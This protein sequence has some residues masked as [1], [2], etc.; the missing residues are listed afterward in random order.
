MSEKF[1][2]TTAIDY[3]NNPPH[4]GTAYE[5][6]CADVIARLHRLLGIDTFF[7]MGNDEHSIN[8]YKK[9]KSLSKTPEEYCDEM[10][11]IFK[12]TWRKLNI[13]YDHFIRT[14]S[15]T[16]QKAVI[17][18]FQR[19]K[20]KG[21]IYKGIY[22]G[23]YCNSCEAYIK[24]Q[25]LLDGR[26]CPLHEIPVERLEEENYFFKLSEFQ[27]RLKS[28]ITEHPEF[29]QPSARRNEIL[30]V[31]DKG[32][33]DISISRKGLDFGIKVADAEDQTIY[34][35]FDAL[36]NYITG[37]GFVD[38]NERFNRYWPADLHIIGKDIT[39]FH[40]LIWPAMLMAIELPL[41]RKIF[42]HGFIYSKGL[43]LSKTKGILIN[44]IDLVEKYGADPLR[45][46]LVRE[47]NFGQDGNFSMENFIN[48]Y[49][50]DLANDYGNLVS[51]ISVMAKKYLDNKIE[52]F[53]DMIA[54]I[55]M[56]IINC[57]YSL[58]SFV[59][60]KLSS[61]SITEI[62]E[63]LFKIITLTNTY[64]EKCSPWNMWKERETK[65]RVRERISTVLFISSYS[66]L[67]VSY[68]LSSVMPETC[69]KIW[70]V[71][72]L[73]LSLAAR[74]SERFFSNIKNF[75]K[76]LNINPATTMILFPKIHME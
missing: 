65:A 32:L 55:D 13:S 36:I 41:P 37:V 28:Y 51:R 8:V 60:E 4:L 31:L 10:E 76:T 11:V 19:I 63:H 5:K 64:L 53:E 6:V 24:P 74:E 66:L 71:F 58:S 7:L 45:Y 18:V 70:R 16:H 48:R 42:A 75:F 67:A 47:I 49:N 38:N 3:V 61:L 39:R 26:L 1:Y 69:E 22:Q 25:D 56:E 2:I 15:L 59:K 46:Y 52:L 33:E 20:E 73:N 40:T 34:V 21:Y 35:W 29:I 14:T 9:A 62:V 12:D 68:W 17:N 43:K 72:D 54:P 57:I 44:P 27:G 30:A 23:F 50:Y